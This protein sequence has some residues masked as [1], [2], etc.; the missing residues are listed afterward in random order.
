MICGCHLVILIPVMN[1]WVDL[2]LALRRRWLAQELMG[3]PIRPA[4]LAD[5]VKWVRVQVLLQ[6]L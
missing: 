6:D 3:A 5:S 2:S 4:I 1:A